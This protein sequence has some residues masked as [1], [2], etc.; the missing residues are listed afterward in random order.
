[1]TGE[2]HTHRCIDEKDR[3]SEICYARKYC[4]CACGK[5][6]LIPRLTKPNQ[7]EWTDLT[8]A[9]LNENLSPALGR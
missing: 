4:L 9:F 5:V 3:S 2:V 7:A 6:A 8:A 1:V